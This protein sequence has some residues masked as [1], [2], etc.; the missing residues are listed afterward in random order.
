MRA[1]PPKISRC[2]S[3]HNFIDDFVHNFTHDE[4]TVRRL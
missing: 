1:I 3:V 4:S 2:I